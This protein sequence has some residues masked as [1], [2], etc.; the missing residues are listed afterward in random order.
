MRLDSIV[1][2]CIY[3]YKYG[4]K[5]SPFPHDD[6]EFAFSD[7][8]DSCLC[9]HRP[10]F[11]WGAVS[12]F[13]SDNCCS[14]RRL[15]A[16]QGRCVS[17]LDEDSADFGLTSTHGSWGWSPLWAMIG[18][19][20][21]LTFFAEFHSA[22]M[23]L[24]YREQLS[25]YATEWICLAVVGICVTIIARIVD[26]AFSQFIRGPSSVAASRAAF[27]MIVAAAVVVGVQA[28]IESFGRGVLGLKIWH[29]LILG[30]VLIAGAAACVERS[31]P[32]LRRIRMIAL[33]I[34]IA[35]GLSLLSSGW[36]HFPSAHASGNIAPSAHGIVRP[37]IVLISIDALSARHLSLYGYARD[38]SPNMASR[39]PV[40][41]SSSGFTR[42]QISRPRASRPSSRG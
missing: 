15:A 35:G 26:A 39:P 28:W 2:Q 27:A 22:S 6:R 19:A 8:R 3:L 14:H 34:A 31:A 4:Q 1:K 21:P 32:I 9:I 5:Q 13:L 16:H 29:I 18:V 38:T 7:R 36:I 20:L 12:A 24:R 42:W 25:L 37:N 41:W 33:P 23:Y 11:C 40:R 10:E 17:S 30:S